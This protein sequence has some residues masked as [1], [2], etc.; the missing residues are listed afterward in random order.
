MKAWRVF[1]TSWQNMISIVAADN[2]GKAKA[3]VDRQQRDAGYE[4]VFTRLRAKR[5]A[6]YDTEDTGNV[7][8]LGWDDGYVRY[9]CLSPTGG[10]YDP[11]I[12]KMA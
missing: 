10:Y 7:R 4:A 9:G 5:A 12:E 1:D 3:H 2:A 8:T 6:E 11:I